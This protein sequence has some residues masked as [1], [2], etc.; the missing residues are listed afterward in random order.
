M[1]YAPILTA[2]QIARIAPL[3]SERQVRAEEVL[4]QPNDATP[5]VFVVLREPSESSP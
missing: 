5:P 3:A 2:E 1:S 4:Y